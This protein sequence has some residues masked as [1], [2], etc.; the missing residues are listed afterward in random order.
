M[1]DIPNESEN[2]SKTTPENAP[3]QTK[4]TTQPASDTEL[5]LREAE[6]RLGVLVEDVYQFNARLEKIGALMTMNATPDGLLVIVAS[7][8]DHPLGVQD[9]DSGRTITIDGEPVV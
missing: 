2:I 3:T 1:K 7:I 5:A 8:P 4:N 9:T 6:N